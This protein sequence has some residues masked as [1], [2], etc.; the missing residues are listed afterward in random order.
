MGNQSADALAPPPF[1]AEVTAESI[2]ILTKQIKEDYVKAL[3]R[4]EDVPEGES[5]FDNTFAVLADAHGT[6]AASSA[7][8]TFPAFV[9]SD[10]SVRDASNAAKDDLKQ[11]FDSSFL[12]KKL[13]QKLASVPLSSLGPDSK[14]ELR[15]AQFVL[16]EFERKGAALDDE[17]Q[18]KLLAKMRAVESLCTTFCQNLSEDSTKVAFAPA[19]LEGC[20][21]DFIAGLERDDAGKCLVSLKAPEL[22]P[23][24]Q[25]ATSE[26]TRKRIT[27]VKSKQCMESN[28]DILKEVIGLRHECSQMLGHVSHAAYVVQ[29][30]MAGGADAAADFQWELVSKLR[31]ALDADLACLANLKSSMQV[32]ADAAV[33]PSASVHAWDTAYL[34]TAHKAALGVDEAAVQEYFPMEHVKTETMRIYEELLCLRFKRVPEAQVWHEDVEA[35][36]V[37]DDAGDVRGFVFLDLY[38]RE[39]KYSHQCVYPLAPAHVCA[40]GARLPP[41]CAVV[42][43]MTRPTPQRPALMRFREVETFFHEF[44]HVVHCVC[45]RPKYSFFAWAWSA[46]PWPGG[47]EQDFLEVPSMMLENWMY[48]PAVLQRL[49]K[50]YKTDTNLPDDVITNICKSRNALCGLHYSR[51][52]FLGLY[53]IAIHSTV[54]PYRYNGKED[55][56]A[57]QLYFHMMEH[58]SGIQCP[59]GT[60]PAASWFHLCMGYDAGYYGYLWSEVYAADLFSAF[61]SAG[62]GCMDSG[63]G[64]RYRDTILAPCASEDGMVMLRNFLQR[65]PSAAPFLERVG[66]AQ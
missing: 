51:Q 65:P 50:H 58:I 43:N 14:E 11:M 62:A 52:L 30:K 25:M 64:R 10:K 5:T 39:G 23:V 18:A 6:A 26:T 34:S 28:S 55:L 53:D 19:E 1:V 45:S 2:E 9:H 29:P 49:S 44:G 38:P 66:C 61:Q 63:L 47:V 41:C 3:E 37:E 57:V 17:S 24:T 54:P 20:P 16:R 36:R 40:G 42:A 21:P 35:Y 27:E 12:R 22:V 7:R 33:A 56:D 15:L 32:D 59:P 4:V 48:E 60:F 8:A 31:G 13:Y 46:V